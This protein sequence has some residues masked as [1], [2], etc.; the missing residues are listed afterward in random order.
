MVAKRF[1]TR[2]EMTW[3]YTTMEQPP[4]EEET[5]HSE[6]GASSASR[7]TN[8]PG[9]NN[10]IRTVP[11]KAKEPKDY[12]A[13]GTVAHRLGE[14]ALLQL[15]FL[16]LEDDDI[17]YWLDG[18]VDTVIEQEGFE[19]TI[20]DDLAE[21][22]FVYVK[23]IK[24]TML[25]HN[26][27]YEY[28]SV[29]LS[30]AMTEV[31]PDARGTTD[32]M[33]EIP[34]E[35]LYLWDLKAGKGVPVEVKGNI[36]CMYYA[37]GGFNSTGQEVDEVE[38]RI[39]QPRCYHADGPIRAERY[40]TSQLIGFSAALVTAIE[41]TRK[42]NAPLKSGSHCKWCEAKAICP[43]QNKIQEK[44]MKSEFMAIED[45]ALDASQITK[46]VAF[47][48]FESLFAERAKA[49]MSFLH[50]LAEQ[51]TEI[52]GYKLVQKKS[53]RAWADPVE[54]EKILK[55]VLGG[56]AYPPPKPPKPITPAVADKA[57]KKAKVAF[58]KMPEVT[59]PD[60]GTALVGLEDTRPAVQPAIEAQFQA[61]ETDKVE[62]D[63]NID[64]L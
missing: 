47:L 24:D 58:D 26:A 1:S 41:K 11:K 64:D 56:A 55:R 46:M 2:E 44:V 40:P 14:Q 50:G 33:L 19:I 32:A 23:D 59:K 38:Q 54:A 28:L 4:E 21:A 16:V 36:Q 52:P 37:L 10:L 22:V 20:K 60:N 13:E 35:I 5:T 53:N 42:K 17:Q 48:E 63:D 45:N 15:D 31:A 8:C 9:S 12:A 39:V 27:P 7:W 51:G 57:F 34:F 25:K 43:E 6:V 3:D 61:V 18:W 30:F 49:I 29:E 62:E